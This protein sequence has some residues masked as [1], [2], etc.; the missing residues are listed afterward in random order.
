MSTNNNYIFHN[1]KLKIISKILYLLNIKYV[2]QKIMS[3]LN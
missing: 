2:S 1:E 3:P